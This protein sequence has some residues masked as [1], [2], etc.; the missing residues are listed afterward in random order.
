[1]CV[2]CN[3]PVTK[4]VQR[5]VI[6]PCS[7]VNRDIY[8]FFLKVVSPGYKFKAT[9]GHGAVNYVCRVPCFSN[10]QKAVKHHVALEN[11]LGLLRA[12]LSPNS[13]DKTATSDDLSS[14]QTSQQ[15]CELVRK[16]IV[17]VS[18]LNRHS[19]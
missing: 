1:M 4:A 16:M 18:I 15:S 5:R 12:N 3:S 11:L 2:V 13:L 17:V 9:T 6:Y 19:F 14:Q 7:E 8:E 10:L